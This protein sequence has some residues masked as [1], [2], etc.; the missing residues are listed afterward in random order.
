MEP[1]ERFVRLE[2]R[3]RSLEVDHSG[4][5]DRLIKLGEHLERLDGDIAEIRET[6]KQTASK[7]DITDLRLLVERSVN[8][9]LRDALN[10]VPAKQA[11]AWAVQGVVWAV[12][13]ALLAAAALFFGLS[14]NVPL[15][16]AGR[17]QSTSCT[18]ASLYV[19]RRDYSQGVVRWF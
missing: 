13:A 18:T 15:R 10:S 4:T 12:I 2:D 19:F 6:L 7:D 16:K 17:R 1:D 14:H 8:G 5:K 9:L 11:V 3:I